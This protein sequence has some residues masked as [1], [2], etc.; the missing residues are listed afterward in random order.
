M[1]PI[2]E[3]DPKF[4]SA[5]GEFLSLSPAG[6]HRKVY[7]CK[8]GLTDK[9]VVA[10]L[11]EWGPNQVTF[12]QKA[13][14]LS[15][16]QRFK[17]PLVIQLLVILT[18]AAAMGNFY[19]AS[20]VFLMILLS[21]GLSYVQERRSA[22]AM[23]SLQKKVRITA[24]VVRNGQEK[25]VGIEGI[26]PGDTVV[27]AAGSI[28]PADLR[29]LTAKDFFVSQSALTGESLPVEKSAK[30]GS[31]DARGTLESPNACFMGSNVVSGSA[32]ALVCATGRNTLLG[33][34]S[35]RTVRRKGATNF[36]KGLHNFSMLM[37]HVMVI[38]VAVVFLIVGATQHNWGE[39]LLFGLSIA[40]G[41]TPEMLPVILTVC[42]SR[43]ALLMSKK[44]VIVRRLDAIQN[45]GAMDVLC[46]DK[47]GTL[48]QD[49]VVLERY[50][51]V[52]G[53]ESEDVLRY[54]WMNSYYQTG[55][56][57]L[58]DK[59]VLAH[60]DLDVDHNC[61]KVDEIPFDFHRRRMS[62]IIGYGGRHV[63][64]CKGAV[65]EMSAVCSRYQV[66]G[67]V[68]PLIPLVREDLWGEYRDLSTEGYRVVA[69]AYRE[70]SRS[71]TAFSKEDETGLILL[72]Y[73]TFF[74]PPKDSSRSAIQA[75]LEHGIA[76]KVLTGDNE[77]VSR[78][79]G[80]DVGLQVGHVAT[81]PELAEL[82][83]DDFL[84]K[85][86]EASILA[87]LSPIQKEQ[88]VQTL[89]EQGHVVGFIGDG[90]NDV[91][92]IKS[93]DVGISVDTAVDV[94]KESADIILLEKSLMVLEEGVVEGR[95][96]FGNIVKYIKTGASSNFGN[97]LSILGASCF[98]PFLPMT[99]IQILVNNLL[100][101]VAQIGIPLD[102]VDR[103]Y[104]EKPRKWDITNIWK[105]MMF[106]GPVSSIFDFCT[107]FIMLY[108]FGCGAY[109]KVPLG[110]A[111]DSTS[112]YLASFFHSAWFVE[113]LLTQTLVVYVI[114]T[115]RVPFLQSQPSVFLVLTTFTVMVVGVWLPYSPLAGFFGFVP[116]PPIFWLWITGFMAAYVVLAHRIKTWFSTRFGYL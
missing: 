57:N 74:D 35:E 101:D 58:L 18:V 14:W 26:V 54:A 114:R 42:L 65:E 52:T 66:D 34:I 32:T 77:L 102:N 84:Q 86:R 75:L 36:E 91:M 69:V 83:R 98:L 9:E 40:V 79:I 59:A 8:Q 48:T 30:L 70:F 2:Q 72:G 11:K 4:I 56:R 41:L 19:S 105:F 61:I 88:V 55:L 20:V 28:V 92:A 85:V 100:Y 7:I 13:G 43:G 68:Y 46:T 44:K 94:A 87:R 24:V 106:L 93:A 31:L 17:D 71:K 76:V 116:L 45:F 97:M 1:I 16:F 53:R 50:V 39:A 5:N 23:S 51:D 38:M 49:H 104:I 6:P 112:T 90:I 81:G 115:N 3:Q 113:S 63:L 22:S 109:Q 62:V 108:L 25:E 95:K 67:E 80:M 103:E 12:T 111:V 33:K 89:K 110:V 82:S 78:K 37:V 27:L 10:R 64:I 21:V 96:V 99:P 29:I 73:I 15:V 60:T 47:T 107:F